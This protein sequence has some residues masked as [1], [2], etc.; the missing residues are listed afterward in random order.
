MKN[1]RYI[2]VSMGNADVGYSV[3]KKRLAVIV[4]TEIYFLVEKLL[5]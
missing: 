2:F 3:L 5:F 4:V 1:D